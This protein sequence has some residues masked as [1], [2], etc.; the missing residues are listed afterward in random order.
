MAQI[1]VGDRVRM[2]EEYGRRFPQTQ[3]ITFSRV[4]TA[5]SVTQQGRMSWVLWDG[6][7]TKDPVCTDH[8]EVVVEAAM[9]WTKSR[10][11]KA[12]NT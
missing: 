7:K 8:L 3:G 9:R 10:A 4:G 12:N 2:T 11:T 1:Q 5:T 6:R